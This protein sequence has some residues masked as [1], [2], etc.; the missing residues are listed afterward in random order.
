MLST[1]RR[2]GECERDGCPKGSSQV[3]YCIDCATRL[4]KP[5]WPLYQPHTNNRKGRDGLE[6]ER[7]Q[8]QIFTKLRGILEP[9]YDEEQLEEL[10][11]DD[12]ST[13]WFGVRR[14]KNGQPLFVDYDT[15]S[16]VTSGPSSTI[17]RT[18]RYPQLASFV[19][20]TNAG[21]STLIKMLIRRG[22][23][24][25]LNASLSYPTP[26]AGS[27]L[28]AHTPTSA[29]VHLY[30]D[31]V[32][33]HDR[34]PLLYA[35]CEGFEGGEKPPLG[36]FDHRASA[37]NGHIQCDRLS[38]GR[39]RLL[40]WANGDEKRS[41][42]YAVRHLYPRILYTFSD[43][44][45]FV[46]RDSKTFETTALRLL[47][48]WGKASLETSVNQP[49]LPHAIIALN[50]TEIGVSS[51]EWDVSKATESLLRANEDCLD[52]LNGQRDFIKVAKDWRS[53][54]REIDN[55]LDLICCYYS[56]FTVV[57]IPTKGRYQLLEE[58]IW[59]LHEVISNACDSSFQ[60]KLKARM[61]LH[62]DELDIYLQ[63]AYTHFALPSGLVD[64]F[65]FMKV[66]LKH[67]P[68]PTDFKGHILQLA[69]SIRSRFPAMK[70][71]RIFHLLGDLV[72][73]CIMLDCTR[74]RK[75]RPQDMFAEYQDSCSEALEEFCDLYTP[76]EYKCG[77]EVC[78]NVASAHLPKGHQNTKGKWI[79]DGRFRS[80]IQPERFWPIWRDEIR[81][82]LVEF[83]NEL[84]SVSSDDAKTVS[85]EELLND[86]HSKR[87]TRLYDALGSADKFIS[88]T[89]CLCC[90]I[91]APLHTLPCGHT[92]CSRCVRSY[93]VAVRGSSKS[94][95]VLDMEFCPL[96]S[97]LDIW[98]SPYYVRFKPEHAGVRLLSLDG[99]GMRGIVEL[100]VLRAVQKQLGDHIPI[101]AFFDLIVGTSTGGIIAL[102]F[103]VKNWSIKQCT[104]TFLNLCDKAFSKRKL[105]SISFLRH[106]VTLRHA[107]KYETTP[108]REVL[109]D[110]F[111]DQPL[112]GSDGKATTAP[113][114]KVAV[115]ATD[116]SGKRAIVIANYN[117]RDDVR[118]KQRKLYY[119]FLRP[120]D[121]NLELQIWEA[122]AATSA[123]PSYFKPFI[124]EPTER[125]YLDGALY[126]NNPVRLV[127]S[128][129]QLLWPDVANEHP[130][131]LLSIGTG[132]ERRGTKSHDPL[133][134]YEISQSKH[135][136]DSRVLVASTRF[137]NILHAENAWLDFCEIATTDENAFRYVRIN[138]E[139]SNAPS[140]D[141]VAQI[142]GVQTATRNALERPENRARVKRVAH[143]LVASSFYYERTNVPRN[144]YNGYACTGKICC[145]FEDESDELRAFGD[146]L[147]KLQTK[148]FQLK[149]EIE[150]VTEQRVVEIVELSTLVISHMRDIASFSLPAPAI[151]VRDKNEK[152]GISLLLPGRSPTSERYMISGFPRAIMTE[153]RVLGKLCT[154][155]IGKSGHLLI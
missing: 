110:I 32:L 47:L 61:L 23:E 105:Q 45:V 100:E 134:D 46:L 126:H 51:D 74:H 53:K 2:A 102:G 139:L 42:S 58:Q 143:M 101:Q 19:G 95:S 57:R 91:Q 93:G 13:T 30:V 83:D 90:L 12:L 77:K 149:F 117:R 28:H 98:P 109:K 22:K 59:K 146:Y 37:T 121:P 103:G 60:A 120:D 38:P 88:H 36:A 145:R 150:N 25:Q 108:L 125:T 15:F 127:R 3:Y 9:D 132:Q 135:R 24:E 4:C 29:D 26:I 79:G 78:V 31:P 116:G 35:D 63:S 64:P 48:E 34:T 85:A 1:E 33:H 72:A 133:Y 87:M 154:V 151:H 27:N 148:D 39:P 137:D 71:E 73:S 11:G 113:A 136:W 118:K 96:H 122:A 6:H 155:Q 20:Q 67:N 141:D 115:T 65:N 84:Q 40:Q 129:A 76:C 62:A 68:I 123:A 80:K 8:H 7:T 41:R 52:A 92:L 152:I 94:S 14:N 21:K 144:V 18:K 140:L 5:C 16:T 124:H 153:D 106:F 43:V 86:I 75:G 99:G 50:N 82:A 112:F 17:D 89:T 69:L 107:S 10:L 114:P 56:T 142:K 81:K 44:V 138:P 119:D 104:E 54:G 49:T 111:G 147:R 97:E 70:S 131:I 66:S 130:D 128:E 55:V